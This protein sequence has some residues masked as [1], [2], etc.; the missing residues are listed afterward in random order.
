MV[1]NDLGEWK[2]SLQNQDYLQIPIYSISRNYFFFQLP[3]SDQQVTGD[4]TL[5]IRVKSLYGD[6]HI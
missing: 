3:S 5:V 2:T 4:F 1:V 6:F